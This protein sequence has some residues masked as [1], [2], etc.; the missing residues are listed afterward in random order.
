MQA[1]FI[2]EFGDFD[3]TIAGN[4]MTEAPAAKSVRWRKRRREV[5]ERLFMVGL[6]E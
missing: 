6:E 5:M 2:F 3:D 4:P 1:M